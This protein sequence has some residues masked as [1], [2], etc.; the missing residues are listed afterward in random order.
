MMSPQL[1]KKI[2]HL[3]NTSEKSID[4]WTKDK[5]AHTLSEALPEIQG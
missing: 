3:I 4:V 5:A 2:G 1:R